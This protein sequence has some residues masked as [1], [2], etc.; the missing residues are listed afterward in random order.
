MGMVENQV[1]IYTM[2][3]IYI[4]ILHLLAT[5]PENGHG[6]EPSDKGHKRSW[7]S[8]CPLGIG[9]H[10]T[11]HLR[12]YHAPK[13]SGTVLVKGS[14]RKIKLGMTSAKWTDTRTSPHNRVGCIQG[15]LTEP[16]NVIAKP[17]YHL[18]KVTVIMADSWQLEKGKYH[19]PLWEGKKVQWYYRPI[20]LTSV[21]EKVMQ[22]TLLGSYFQAHE[23][24]E[25]TGN[26]WQGFSKGELCLTNLIVLYNERTSSIDNGKALDVTLALAKLVTWSH[27]ILTAKWESLDSWTTEQMKKIDW[28]ARLNWL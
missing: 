1:I 12:N 4:C 14:K 8:Q 10:I 13:A 20:S 3:R 17:L 7:G 21:L 9:F 11:A 28:T 22:Q 5:N 23:G 19:D 15:C 6:G 24:K 16:A 26:S 18:R 27:R 25:M 2:S